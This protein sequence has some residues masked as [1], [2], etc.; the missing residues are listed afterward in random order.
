[1]VIT[2]PNELKVASTNMLD[3]T[4]LFVGEKKVGKTHFCLQWPGAFVLEGEPGN[5]NHLSGNYVDV[6]NWEEVV[7]YIDAIKAN[8]NYCKTLILDDIPSFY[9]YCLAFVRQKLGM[10]IDKKSDWDVWEIT[11]RRF[12]TFI[13]DVQSLPCCKIYTAHEQIKDIEVRADTT[14]TILSNSMSKQCKEVMDKW[15]TLTGYIFKTSSDERVMQIQGDSWVKASCGFNDKFLK[16]DGTQISRIPM[17]KTA[18]EGFENFQ[19]AFNNE[20]FGKLEPP[21]QVFKIPG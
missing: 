21:K 12:T 2:L 7:Q 4:Y 15:I 13:K 9:E 18:K 8:P 17:G 5:A 14:V 10:N 16:S 20:L 19:K 11:R 1:M 6:S 3:H